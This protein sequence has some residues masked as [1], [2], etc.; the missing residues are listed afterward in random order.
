MLTQEVAEHAVRAQVAVQA[1]AEQNGVAAGQTVPHVPQ[2][3]ALL[4]VSTQLPAQTLA[5]ALHV[6]PAPAVAPEV[7]A[8]AP[9]PPV[10]VGG[11]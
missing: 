7:P 9:A 11:V 10:P 6:A 2:L 1:L 3:V 8:V 4:V 5:G